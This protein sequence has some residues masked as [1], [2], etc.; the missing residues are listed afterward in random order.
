LKFKKR[1]APSHEDLSRSTQHGQTM[2]DNPHYY[3]PNG[4]SVSSN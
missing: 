2:L 3:E 1:I 4:D